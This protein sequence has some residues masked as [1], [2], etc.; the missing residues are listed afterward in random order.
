MHLNLSEVI[1]VPGALKPF[2]C[3]LETDSLDFPSIES[4]NSPPAARGAVKNIAGALS[5][6]ATVTMSM[7]CVCD[8]CGDVFESEK[9]Q[10]IYVPLAASLI[11]DEN[12]DIYLLEGDELAL[13]E[14]L[15]TC[16]ILDMETKFLCD[17]D[18]AGLCD[19]CG[20]SLNHEPCSC[21][22]KVD[23]RLAALG[24]LLDDM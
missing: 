22:A 5:L 4:F 7:S 15:E 1:E 21:K 12:A 19:G 10:E 24:Q 9:V 13:S 14:L 20:A 11:D 23:P 17:E 3:E 16:L 2:F 8:R 6:E 18:C